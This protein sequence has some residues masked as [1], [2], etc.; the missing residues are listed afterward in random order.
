MLQHTKQTDTG[1]YLF[2]HTFKFTFLQFQSETDAA[3][4]Q[5]HIAVVDGDRSLWQKH[6]QIVHITGLLTS[7]IF[8]Q[9]ADVK[10]GSVSW[11]LSL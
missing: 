1:L 7:W 8:K 4:L 9:W 6:S 3:G 2:N 5:R 11:Y 10:L